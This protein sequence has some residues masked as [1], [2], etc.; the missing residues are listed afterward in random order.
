MIDRWLRVQEGAPGF[1]WFVIIA[2]T[3]IAQMVKLF[4]RQRP[5]QP[6]APP[7]TGDSE[8]E[9]PRDELSEFLRQLTGTPPPAPAP[10][11]VPTAP[12]RPAQ[13]PR[14]VTAQRVRAV[15]P[16][17]PIRPLAPS[18]PAPVASIHDDAYKPL[19]KS[20]AASPLQREILGMVSR[21]KGLRRAILLR[22]ILG[23][24]RGTSPLLI[25]AR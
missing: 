3:I 2:A 20:G 12:A 13:H 16:P 25:Q 22:E 11:P 10:P 5:S 23:Q 15:P 24:P 8:R 18:R 17:A 19:R 1:L 6:P 14:R 21:K 9:A 4:R 7:V